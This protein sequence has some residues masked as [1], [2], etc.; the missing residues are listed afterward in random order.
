MTALR[1]T[2]LDEYGLVSALRTYAAQYAHRTGIAVT[3][4]AAPDFPRLSSRKEVALFRISQE[5]LNNVVKHAEATKVTVVLDR[6]AT[7]TRC[8][9]TDNGKGMASSTTP[10]LAGVGYGLTIMR[11]RA[12]LVGGTF[13]MS[14]VS[15]TGTS[16]VIGIGEGE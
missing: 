9:I 14:S 2:Q 13:E 16:V 3:I 4:Q 10:R 5:A 15:G 7:S 8:T 6:D 1:P 12:E 11:E